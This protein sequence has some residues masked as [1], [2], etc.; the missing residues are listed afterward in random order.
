MTRYGYTLLSEQAPPGQLVADAERAEAAGF[1]F[2]VMSDHYYPWLQEQ[3]HSPYAWSVLGAV[4]QATE[5]IDLM[6]FVTCPI[7]RYHP[8]VVAQKAATMALLSEGRFGLGLGAGENLNERV[9]GPWP[10]VTQRHDMFAEALE[11]IRHLLDGASLSY[12]GEYFDVGKAQLFDLPPQPP[13]IAVAVSGPDSCGLAAEHGDAMVAAQP[14]PDLVRMF[15][16]A[17]GNGRR[18][19]QVPI[20]YGPDEQ[21]CRR[22]AHEQFRWGALGWK[23]MAEL[24]DPASFAAATQ[25]LREED[26]ARTVS[27]GPDVEQHVAAVMKFRDAGFTDVTLVQVG[28]DRQ[29]EFLHWASGELLPALRERDGG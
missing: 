25:H 2:A 5:R 19:G 3:G 1:D 17:G 11:I 12:R 18:Y 28:G 16:E 6:S 26:I 14:D 27:C 10:P 23:V 9:V 7:R 22:V 24:P 21:E 13:T 29:Q 20:C 15:D 8:A 4:A